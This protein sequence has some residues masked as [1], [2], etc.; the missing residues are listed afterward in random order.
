MNTK[1]NITYLY[2]FDFKS[3]KLLE[4]RNMSDRKYLNTFAYIFVYIME[5]RR[6]ITRGGGGACT[7]SEK[8]VYVTPMGVPVGDHLPTRNGAPNTEPLTHTDPELQFLNDFFLYF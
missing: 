5:N 3:E 4:F 7:N 1:T 6:K 2:I 8:S